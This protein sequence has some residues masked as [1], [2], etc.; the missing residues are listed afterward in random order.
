MGVRSLGLRQAGLADPGRQKS[1]E[2]NTYRGTGD[3]RL[4]T[5]SATAFVYTRSPTFNRLVPN[6]G[7]LNLP[8]VVKGEYFPMDIA[9]R[10]G[11]T[12][13]FSQRAADPPAHATLAA[14]MQ[15]YVR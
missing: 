9:N 11:A 12:L 2:L 7:S 4:L 1:Q 5:S 13:H 6:F 14:R 8:L 10:Y 15:L 3:P